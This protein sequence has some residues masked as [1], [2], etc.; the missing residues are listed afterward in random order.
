MI[1]GIV[2]ARAG[3]KRLKN[4]NIRLLNNKP[5]LFY[6]IESLLYSEAISRVLVT[7]D[8]EEYS[9]LIRS[10]YA[11]DVDVVIRPSSFATD[12]SKVKDEIDRLIY[13]HE[14]KTEWIL[15]A[16]PSS[17]L[18]NNRHVSGII[19]RWNEVGRR[20]IFSVTQYPFPIQFALTFDN[21]GG[22]QS[23]FSDSPMITGNTRSQDIKVCYRPNGA[24]YLFDRNV[25]HKN[26]FYEGALVYEMAQDCSLDV[27]TELDFMMIELMLSRGLN[28]AY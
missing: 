5:M 27:D 18:R 23:V 19:D 14:I 6:S 22:W 15:L 12:E 25:A 1:T 10:E 28:G 11:S 24:M 16:L 2:P 8:S 26:T 4:K 7:T 21:G 9:D 17:P 3:S 20:P 13:A